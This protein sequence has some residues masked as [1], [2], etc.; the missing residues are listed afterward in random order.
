MAVHTT[1]LIHMNPDSFTSHVVPRVLFH[2]CERGHFLQEGLEGWGIRSVLI[3]RDALQ[4]S[5]LLYSE[6]LAEKTCGDL[7]IG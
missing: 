7:G 1:S 4:G 5:R 6:G 2:W 3:D